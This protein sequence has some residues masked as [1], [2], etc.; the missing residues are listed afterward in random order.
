MV[1]HIPVLTKEVLQYIAPQK[2]GL[3]VDATFGGGGHT[4]AILAAS[5]ESRVIAFDWD[6]VAF[7][8]NAQAILDEFPDRLT[9]INK[10][11]THLDRE[12]AKRGI[13][14]VDGILADFGTS[15]YQLAHKAGFSFQ[16]DSPL[17]MRMSTGSFQTTAADIVHRSSEQE[18][19][20]IFWTYGGEVQARQIARAIVRARTEKR[21]KTTLQLAE[22]VT[23]VIAPKYGRGRT[24]IHPA[25]KVFQALRIVVNNECD[26]IERFLKQ[27]HAEI[28]P[29]GRIVCISFHSLE[30]RIV[31]QYFREH[32]DELES[33]T[34]RVVEASEEELA[35]NPSARSAKLRAVTK[36]HE[37][38]A[39]SR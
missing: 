29:E 38:L 26:E 32:R 12:L 10:S 11:F 5:P 30:D 37:P 35:V 36:R 34:A 33:L 17:D 18:L 4:R 21:I 31:K 19:G 9:I 23:K 39:R 14:Q 25:T 22:I 24:Q 13:A 1:Y 6:P 8:Q 2:G 15:Q 3:Y 28:A 27:A 7:E 16:V 20:H